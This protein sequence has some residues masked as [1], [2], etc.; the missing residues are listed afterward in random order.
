MTQKHLSKLVGINE[1]NIRN[2]INKLKK[3]GIIKRI[4]SRNTGYWDVYL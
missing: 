2:N 1:R 4:G 3:I